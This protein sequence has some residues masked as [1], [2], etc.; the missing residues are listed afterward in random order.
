MIRGKEKK[1]YVLTGHGEKSITDVDR[2]GYS[3]VKEA[4][5]RANYV[6]QDTLFLAQSGN[7]PDD[8]SLLLIPGPTTPLLDSEIAAV[9]TYL[10]AAGTAFIMLDPGVP[11]GMEEMLEAWGVEV[12]DNYIVESG[13]MGRLFNL[14]YS[15]PVATQYGRHPITQ[16]HQGLMTAYLMARSVS[17][18]GNIG[19]AETV[20]LVSTSGQSW[21]ETDLSPLQGGEP[22]EIAFDPNADLRGPVSVGVAVTAD[23]SR[24]SLSDA[25]R[26]T[27]IVVFGDSDFANNQFFGFQGNG[28]LFMNAVSW[29]MEEGELIAIRQKERGFRPISL[30]QGDE[31]LL[32]WISIVLLPGIPLVAGLLVWY[33]RR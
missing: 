5:E 18:V 31:Q 22:T 11:S 26:K 1:V 24:P 13:G 12:G 28:D 33:R 15:V 19:A 8:C 16:K 30:T 20:E 7:V 23:P 29:L 4:L 6:V 2:T 9:R 21:G 17:R 27:R 32:F 25:E 10:E 3:Q 14:D